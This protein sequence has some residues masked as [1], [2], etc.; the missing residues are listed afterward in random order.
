MTSPSAPL[1]VLI[2]R[3]AHGQGLPLPAYATPGA[4]GADLHAAEDAALPPGAH[5]AVATG[6]AIA[7]P[8]GWEAQVRARSGLAAK[9]GVG[10]SNGVGHD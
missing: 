5:R 3:L 9:H 6:F 10:L 8:E 2:T 7:L 4:A 1:R